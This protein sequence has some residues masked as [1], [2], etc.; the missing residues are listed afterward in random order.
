MNTQQA[1]K[2]QFGAMFDMALNVVSRFLFSVSLSVATQSSNSQSS[3]ERPVRGTT[4]RKA[5]VLGA[6]EGTWLS[7]G[8]A[9]AKLSRK[10][11]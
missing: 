11:N 5:S 8:P 4:G 1:N 2:S 6:T 10:T 3:V 7:C 9:Q